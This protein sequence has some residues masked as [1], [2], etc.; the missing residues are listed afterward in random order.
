MPAFANKGAR[1]W[2]ERQLQDLRD[3]HH[4]FR[5]DLTETAMATGRTRTECD[6]ALFVLL[7]RSATEAAI[8]MAR[9]HP[10]ALVAA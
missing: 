5:G 3:L 6:V 9:R 10:I 4:S 7:G 1:P 2:T 8:V